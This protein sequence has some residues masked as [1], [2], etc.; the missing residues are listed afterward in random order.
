MK[1][2]VRVGEKLTSFVLIFTLVSLVVVTAAIVLQSSIKL[3]VFRFHDFWKIIALLAVV[4][5]LRWKQP[6]PNANFI[7]PVTLALLAV[8][9]IDLI[10]IPIDW[11]SE[12]E[13]SKEWIPNFFDN[14]LIS[15]PVPL[16]F[17]L[18]CGLLGVLDVTK[19]IRTIYMRG[20]IDLSVN[21]WVY[22]FIILLHMVGFVL[23][24]WSM[25]KKV[26]SC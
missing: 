13:H 7:N 24:Q 14:R 5:Y 4:I 6:E 20:P 21:Y 11:V 22:S 19:I 15:S 25:K 1:L 3:D 17:Y 18:T 10:F 26:V 2:R 16:D 8:V 23:I 9:L 12:T